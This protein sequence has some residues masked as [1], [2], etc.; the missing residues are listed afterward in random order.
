MPRDAATEQKREIILARGAGLPL[1]VESYKYHCLNRKA[2]KE[3]EETSELQVNVF[4]ALGKTMSYTWTCST[5]EYATQ[6]S[7]P[8]NKRRLAAIV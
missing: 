3:C 5:Q 2:R 7:P 4:S 8:K 1:I 6:V